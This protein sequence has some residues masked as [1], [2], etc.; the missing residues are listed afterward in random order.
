MKK[1]FAVS[2][3]TLL[4]LSLSGCAG[5]INTKDKPL[6]YQQTLAGD[7]LALARCIENKLLADSR[8]YMRVLHYKFRAYPDIDTSEI[9]AYDTRFLPY[10]YASNSPHNPDGIEDYIGPSPEIIPNTQNVIGAEYIYAFALTIQQTSDTKAVATLKGN[11]FVGNIAWDY[12][13]TCTPSLQ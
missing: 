4:I 10:V 2:I 3:A 1:S 9:Y 6:L 8:R 5:L 11:K 13:Q 7:Y 12:L